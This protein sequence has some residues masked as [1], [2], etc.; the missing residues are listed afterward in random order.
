MNSLP[1]EIAKLGSADLC[2]NFLR[3]ALFGFVMWYLFT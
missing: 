2:K 3:E 1:G